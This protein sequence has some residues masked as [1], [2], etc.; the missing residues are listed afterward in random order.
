M[1]KE[2]PR[3]LASINLLKSLK[4]PN[5]IRILEMGCRNGAIISEIART[6]NSIDLFGI[7]IDEKALAE[8]AIEKG[9]ITQR[10]DLN[11]DRLPYPDA[12]FD[13]VLME[14][15]IEHLVNPDNA[16]QE[17]YRTLKPGGYFLVTTPNLA[18]WL[19]R[20]ALF[21][22]YQP[23]WTENSIKYNVGKLKRT[24]AESRNGHLRLYTLRALKELLTIYNFKVINSIGAKY[25]NIPC[26][27]LFSKIASQAEIVVVLSQK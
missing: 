4:L 7:D 20:L 15:V 18:W 17:A 23:Y 24:N 13:I 14:E 9:I 1:R 26:N 12:S 27:G 3:I 22:G 6:L 5:H 19:N 8:A 25:N 11:T 10:V 2:Y 21:L 16:I